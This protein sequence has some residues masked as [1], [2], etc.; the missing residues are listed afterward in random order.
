MTCWVA[1]QKGMGRGGQLQGVK[2]ELQA[3][4]DFLTHCQEGKEG[5]RVKS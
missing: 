5:T 2:G 1:V 4:H 3:A